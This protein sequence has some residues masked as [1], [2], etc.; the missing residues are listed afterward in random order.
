[1][2]PDLFFLNAAFCRLV[3]LQFPFHETD[4]AEACGSRIYLELIL[5][6]FA[7]NTVDETPV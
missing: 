7:R 2:K 4:I 5:Q 3:D 1:M 6:V